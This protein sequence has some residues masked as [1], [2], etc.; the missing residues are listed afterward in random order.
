MTK[1]AQIT[2]QHVF[3][4]INV[5]SYVFSTLRHEIMTENN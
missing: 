2:N 5:H 3:D 1:V 4:N